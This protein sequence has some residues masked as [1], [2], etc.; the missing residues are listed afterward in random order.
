MSGITSPVSLTSA[1]TAQ[2]LVAS[3]DYTDNGLVMPSLRYCN[4]VAIR[5][6]DPTKIAYIG[7]QVPIGVG[8]TVSSTVFNVILDA[9]TPAITIGPFDGGN[10]VDLGATYWDGN[11]TD[12]TLAIAPVQV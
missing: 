2:P 5:L 7:Y 10:G 1:G 4:R 8:G 9:T 11:T 6:V 12:M 3:A